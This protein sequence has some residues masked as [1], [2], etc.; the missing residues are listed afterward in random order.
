MPN[1]F[2]RK[3]RHGA[4]LDED[5]AE[6]LD[7]LI[8]APV[9]VAAGTDVIQ[10][11][12][13]PANVHLVI[14]G[15]AQRYKIVEDG[16]RQIVGLLVPGDFCDL[17]V[18]ILGRMDQS[19]ATLTRCRIVEIPHETIH[20]LTAN[21]PG[22]QRALWWATLVDEAVL[23]E[24]LTN[25]GRRQARARLAHFLCEIETRLSAIGLSENGEFRLPLTQS[26]M[27]DIL[28]ISAVHVNRV[29][30][31]LRGEGLIVI[32]G[33]RI[34][35]PNVDRLREFAEFVPDYLHLEPPSGPSRR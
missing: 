29:L 10:A 1:Y 28:G 33:H 34:A 14:E 22:I 7:A 6:R 9:E 23:R 15:F 31:E 8:R 4:R 2:L 24:W 25:M 20:D 26:D 17:H 18:A 3:L 35:I 5:D 21:Y 27:A 13:K 16:G 32:Q 30:Q 11:A 12:E 19:I